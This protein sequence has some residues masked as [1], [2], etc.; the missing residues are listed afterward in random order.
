MSM[1]TNRSK[2]DTSFAASE[3]YIS[4]ESLSRFKCY[5]GR[6]WLNIR[7]EVLDIFATTKVRK[8]VVCHNCG[9]VSQEKE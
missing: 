4:M 9:K 5:H 7:N 8:N 2:Q 3:E 6:L 1:A